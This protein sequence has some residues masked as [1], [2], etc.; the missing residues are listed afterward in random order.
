MF[1]SAF[2]QKHLFMCSS[3]KGQ[4]RGELVAPIL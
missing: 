2:K 3:K 1:G 4:G